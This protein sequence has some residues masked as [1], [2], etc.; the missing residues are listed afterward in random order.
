MKLVIGNKNYSSWSFRPWLA[1][2][3]AGIAFEEQL[4]RL[5][6][7]EFAAEVRK[8]N[9]AGKV[10]VLIDNDQVVWESL[11]IMEYLAETFPEKNLWPHDK[12]ARA[13]ARCAANEM[14]GGFQALR[15]ACP[16]NMRRVNPAKDR[17]EAVA[18]D[19]VRICQLWNEARASY[20]ANGAFLYGQFSITDAMFAPVVS[21]FK[22]YSIQVDEVSAA[23]MAAMQALPAYQEWQQAGAAEPWI[24]EEEEVD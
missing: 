6:T 9:P 15:N 22:T 13:H 14:H 3:V 2:R 12:A 18:K 21:R 24:I 11:A 4:I 10:P 1:M 19:V 16:M 8:V 7:D 23:Y 5:F 17:G 20:G